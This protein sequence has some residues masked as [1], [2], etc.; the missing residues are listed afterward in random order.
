MLIPSAVISLI[1]WLFR[2]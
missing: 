1:V 2:Q